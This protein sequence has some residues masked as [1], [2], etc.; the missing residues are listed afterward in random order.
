[1]KKV[2]VKA[3]WNG[4][5]M[6]DLTFTQSQFNQVKKQFKQD[7]FK[8]CDNVD[9]FIDVM[10]NNEAYYHHLYQKNGY[11]EISQREMVTNMLGINSVVKRGLR[12]ND[13][14]YGLLFMSY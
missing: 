8:G 4:S 13:D 11:Y 7:F 10:N 14:K 2:N 12:P 5:V 6:A 1:M 9:E 3:F